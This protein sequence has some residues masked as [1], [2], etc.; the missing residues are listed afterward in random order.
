[1]TGRRQVDGLE[2]LLR[3]VGFRYG[4]PDWPDKS[5]VPTV[6]PVVD[7]DDFNFGDDATPFRLQCANQCVRDSGHECGVEI[8]LGDIVTGN[9]V[10]VAAAQVPWMVL[11]WGP[12]FH[13][14]AYCSVSCLIEFVERRAEWSESRRHTHQ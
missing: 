2:E 8:D 6:E 13:Q 7:T 9:W 11:S 14:L 5:D 12:H 1:M 3:E 10:H 4:A